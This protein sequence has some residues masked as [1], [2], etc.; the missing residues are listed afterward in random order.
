MPNYKNSKIYKIVDNTNGNIYIG[1]TTQGL[2]K[3]LGEHT[4]KY[5]L[6]LSGKYHYV[7]SFEILKNKNYDIILIETV[8]CS[9]K[10]ELHSVERKHIETN[11]CVNM[12]VPTRTCRQYYHQ[13]KTEI[14]ET[15]IC[16]CGL[17]SLKKHLD[18]HR[19]STRHIAAMK[20]L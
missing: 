14:N 12:V 19:N 2:S 1:S 5:G 3:R 16:E 17:S 4:R 11:Q 10:E 13:H 18:R 20:K 9:T 7:S 8:K 15:V 6:Y